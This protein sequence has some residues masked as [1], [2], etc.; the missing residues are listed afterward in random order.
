MEAVPSLSGASDDGSYE[1]STG[2]D[3][4]DGSPLFRPSLGKDLVE[5]RLACFLS[6]VSLDQNVINKV[7]GYAQVSR[8]SERPVR[9]VCFIGAGY[10]GMLIAI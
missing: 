7:D 4:P 6:D 2:P 1:V 9:R 10:V 8:S 3:T 5:K